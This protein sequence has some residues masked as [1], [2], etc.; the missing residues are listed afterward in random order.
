M[1]RYKPCK[2]CKGT[3]EC[4][5]CNGWGSYSTWLGEKECKDCKGTG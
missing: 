1:T 2:K 4:K 5:K 3:T